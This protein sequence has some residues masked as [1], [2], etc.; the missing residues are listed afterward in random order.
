VG[1]GVGVG[2]SVCM[3][4][5]VCVCV[6]VCVYIHR[7]RE[8]TLSLTHTHTHTG[9]FLKSIELMEKAV[10]VESSNP[11]VWAAYLR[12][13]RRVF[14]VYIYSY[15]YIFHDSFIFA[16]T[17]P[18]AW[19]ALPIGGPL[20]MSVGYVSICNHIYAMTYFHLP[21]LILLRKLP[22]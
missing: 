4:M 22:I 20:V 19:A 11:L 9:A 7:G 16:T 8:R 12:F 14:G 3:C 13:T 10:T 15:S 18:V 6:C 2:V 5:C 1:V 17:H 21:R